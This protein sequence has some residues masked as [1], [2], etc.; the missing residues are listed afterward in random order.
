MTDQSTS[1]IE[2]MKA[3]AKLE[4]KRA[5]KVWRSGDIRDE[6]LQAVM[7]HIASKDTRPITELIADVCDQTGISVGDL[8]SCNRSQ[9]F[10]YP[11]MFVIW[12][13]KKMGFSNKD[14]ADFFNRDH[15]TIISAVRRIDAI[16]GATQ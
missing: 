10:S 7:D 13:S 15:T 2:A 4:S 16:L 6:D 12:K 3:M 5:V 1:A 11:R 8:M 14:L 9:R